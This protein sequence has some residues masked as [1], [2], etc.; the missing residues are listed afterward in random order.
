MQTPQR[1]IRCNAIPPATPKKHRRANNSHVAFQGD[2]NVRRLID[3]CPSARA[4][5]AALD[6]VAS[7]PHLPIRNEGGGLSMGGGDPDLKH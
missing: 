6:F 2:I 3:L 7:L 4:M 1:I 5:Q